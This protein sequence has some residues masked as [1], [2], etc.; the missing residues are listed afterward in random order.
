MCF[1]RRIN[2]VSTDKLLKN[3][4]FWTGNDLETMTDPRGRPLCF[5][6]LGR[7]QKGPCR[8]LVHWRQSDV[9]PQQ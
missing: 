9:P 7:T 1:F 6:F 8:G 3:F 2:Q 5:A 4:H